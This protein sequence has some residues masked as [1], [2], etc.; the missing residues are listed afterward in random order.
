[1]TTMFLLIQL[2]PTVKSDHIHIVVQI[3]EDLPY[4]FPAKQDGQ[5]NSE[6]QQT[7]YTLY[8]QHHLSYS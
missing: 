5:P 7:G 3:F 8:V 4:S 6:I 2:Q 1:M